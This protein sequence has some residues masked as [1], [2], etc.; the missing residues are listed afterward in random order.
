MLDLVEVGA[1]RLPG[2][3]I[4]LED[5]LATVQ[6]YEYTG[7]LQTGESAVS[8]GRPLTAELGPGL[9]GGVFDGML[10]RLTGAEDF[11]AAG[12]RLP[13][14][15]ARP[16][17]CLLSRR[18][19]GGGCAPGHAPRLPSRDRLVRASRSRATRGLGPARVAGGGGR[20]RGRRDGRDRRRSAH[21]ARTQMARAPRA[22]VRRAPA[23]G[24][25]AR[26]GTTGPRPL[27]PGGA[28]RS[29]GAR[30]VRDRQDRPPPADREVVR[31][32]RDRLRRLRRARER[33]GRHPRRSSGSSRTRATTS[34]SSHG[35][36][37]SPTPP[38]CRCS[39]ARRAST[40][41]SR[42]PST[43]ATWAIT[44]S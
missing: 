29:V 7:G 37:S 3:I 35:P 18:P 1:A 16:P 9:L 39:R 15:P 2:E 22:P 4:A 36:S 11:L 20:V 28:R 42:W 17:L 31:R 30:R 32:R 24:G 13:A 12:E 27:L 23:R 25:A 5:G 26:H 41:V 21:R 34:R 14:L 40:P 44:R 8:S 38:T 10:R 6:V 33:D 19:R 43:S